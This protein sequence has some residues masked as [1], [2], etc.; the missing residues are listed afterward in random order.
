MKGALPLTIGEQLKDGRAVRAACRDGSW[1][2]MTGGLAPGH[3][4]ANL[5]MLPGSL[6]A[7]FARFCDANSQAC[8][9]LER[10]DPG[11]YEPKGLA[12]GADIRRDAPRYLV[13]ANGESVGGSPTDV[14]AQWLDDMVGFLIGCSFTFEAALQD[15]GIPIRHLE[16]GVNV[17]MFRTS[18]AC[19]PVG[20]F[21]GPMVV[22]MRP[23]PSERVDEAC[24]ITARFPRVHGAPVSIGNP[25]DIG[26]EDISAP[27]WGDAVDVR[28]GEVPVFWA[29]GVTPQAVA[30][31]SCPPLMITHAPGHMFVT[32]WLD[33]QLADDQTT[34]RARH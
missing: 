33:T 2:A 17:P 27:D 15:A 14:V 16:D 5:V 4:Q 21:S 23:I 28:A 10:T 1:R 25:L 31:A 24:A 22:S 32:D 13:Y 3:V 6:A 18:V 26:I 8:P 20:V 9:L 34:Q 7:D 30:Q 29:C 11:K 19:R 12:P